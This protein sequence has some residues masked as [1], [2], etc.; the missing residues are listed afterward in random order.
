MCS[1]GD[2]KSDD[3]LLL[4]LENNFKTVNEWLKFAEECIADRTSRRN[5]MGSIPIIYK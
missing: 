5:N 2:K 4:Q 3:K 1:S